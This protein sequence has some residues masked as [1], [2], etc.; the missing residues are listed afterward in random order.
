MADRHGTALVTERCAQRL[1]A[2]L[3]TVWITGIDP[4]QKDYYSSLG[5][6]RLKQS[7]LRTIFQ[8]DHSTPLRS[9]KTTATGVCKR[10]RGATKC[11]P[12]PANQQNSI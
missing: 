10:W 11:R 5:G 2:H 9:A 12:Q 4:V 7:V 6:R 3:N 8:S 1:I